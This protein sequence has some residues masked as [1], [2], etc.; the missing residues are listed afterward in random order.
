MEQAAA[1]EI[2]FGKK[3]CLM[4]VEQHSLCWVSGRLADS[5]S[6]V[7]WAKEFRQ[8]PHLRQTTQDGGS[9]LAKGLDTRQRGA[10]ADQPGPGGSARR[11]LPRAA[12]RHAG[13]AD[14]ART[15]EPLLDKADK[16]DRKMRSKEWHTGR[17]PG[18][19][20]GR[21]RLGVAPSVPWMP[22]R[23]P[24]TAWSEV[25]EALRLFTPKGSL[26]TAERARALLASSLAAAVGPRLVEG[27]AGA[28]RPQL[29]TFLEAAQQ[30]IAALP[31]PA[32]VLAAAVR[33]EGLR[34]RPEQLRG[35]G[36]SSGA[37]RGVL[38][39]AGL[40]LS[41]SGA[42]GVAGRC[43]SAGCACVACGVRRA[44]WSASTAWRGCSRVVTAR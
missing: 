43:R 4:V 10:A 22:G 44:W 40:V 19:G 21:A 28:E 12:G 42:G 17:R 1:D 27:A 3:P 7:E 30:G 8:L 13:L 39:A 5:R 2:F 18:Q 38:L 31:L 11:P 26:N 9:G 20:R 37:L 16:L 29:L 41:L 33:V 24:T 15:G 35:E 32:E 36:V 23:R 6:G 14:N 25:A 34:R